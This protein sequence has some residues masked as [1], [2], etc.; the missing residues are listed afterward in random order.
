MFLNKED[1]TYTV[2]ECNRVLNGHKLLNELIID[3]SP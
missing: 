1:A 2:T 3:K